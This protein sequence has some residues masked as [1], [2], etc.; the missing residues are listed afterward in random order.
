MWTNLCRFVLMLL[1]GLVLAYLI[2]GLIWPWSVLDPLNPL[3]ALGYFSEFFEQPWKEMFG[4]DLVAVPDMP[5][6]YVP[7]FFALK[8]PEILLVL[9]AAGMGGVIAATARPNIPL[10]RRAALLLVAVAGALPILIVIATRPAM[11]NGIRHFVFV[12]P[13]LCVLGGLAGAFLLQRLYATAK[14]AAAIAGLALLAGLAMPII[15]MIRLHPYQYTHFNR[16]AGGIRAADD[17]YM[18]DYWGLSFKQ[19]AQELR[20][21]LAGK[22]EQ[23][24]PG[25]PWRIAVCGPHPPAEVELGEEFFATWDPKGADFALMLGEFYC[26]TLEAPVL[27]EIERAGVV[28]A[29]VYDIRVRN[30]TSLFTIPPVTR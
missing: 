29:R 21:K 22:L 18:L 19:A 11:Y 3:R 17:R 9:A 5:R 15:D 12:V 8:L 26:A 7:V 25:R 24:P 14:P 13:P 20:A 6:S 23:P 27:V 30:V 2:M 1:P 10:T 28:F 4:G 16:I